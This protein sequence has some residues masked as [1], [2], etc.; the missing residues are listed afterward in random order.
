MNQGQLV[1]KIKG[2]AVM[3]TQKGGALPRGT[4]PLAFGIT[5]P[6]KTFTARSG[7]AQKENEEFSKEV[8]NVL[9]PSSDHLL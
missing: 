5:G 3:V 2:L 9:K 6:A 7:A 4:S 8:H 1:G